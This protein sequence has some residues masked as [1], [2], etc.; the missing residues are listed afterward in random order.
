MQ[1]DLVVVMP[2]YNEAECIVAVIHSWQ[3]VLNSLSINYKI[4]AINDGSRDTTR[5]QLSTFRNFDNVEVID[6]EN[7]G[8]GPTIL[9]GYKKAIDQAKWVFQCD[10][11]DEMKAEYF[12]ILWKKRDG[13]DA[14]FGTREGREQNVSRKIISA[15][16]R[17]TIRVLFGSGVSDVNTAYRLMRADIL[18]EIVSQI[19]PDTFA[20]NVIISGVFSRLKY[21]IFEYPVPMKTRTTGK[22]SIVKWSLWKAAIKSFF[23][24]LVCRPKIRPLKSR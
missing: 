14:L 11:D 3:N 19:P 6:K 17:L 15:I 12:P 10:S 4:I 7:S 2:I 20:P 23:Q 16:S 21:R 5:E 9:F 8:H 13:Y 1:F 22:V 18:K 24:T